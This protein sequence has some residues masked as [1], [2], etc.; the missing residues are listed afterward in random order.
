VA[1]EKNPD[2]PVLEPR[3]MKVPERVSAR[4]RDLFAKSLVWD[5]TLCG[6][7]SRHDSRPLHRVCI[8]AG[9]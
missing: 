1:V 9:V 3:V 8:R 5:M 4:A 7:I 6:R 2:D